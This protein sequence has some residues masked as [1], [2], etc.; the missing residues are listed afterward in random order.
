MQAKTYDRLSPADA[1]VILERLPARI[2]SAL[3]ERANEIEYPILSETLRE[4]SS[5]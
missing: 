1:A 5:Y 4:R 2:Q 3:I